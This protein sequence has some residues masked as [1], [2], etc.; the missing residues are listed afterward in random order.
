[1]LFLSLS[2]SLNLEKVAY[3][4]N[5]IVTMNVCIWV[6]FSVLLNKD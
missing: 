3:E 6:R 4:V 1:M 2:L 5:H